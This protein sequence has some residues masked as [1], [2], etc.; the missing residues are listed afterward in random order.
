[1]A[2]RKGKRHIPN[3]I[4]WHML[5]IGFSGF[6]LLLFVFYVYLPYLTN[7]QQSITVPDIRGM[8][9]MDA[10]QFLRERR[11]DFAVSVDSDFS[12]AAKPLSVLKQ[13]PV[14]HAKVKEE[15]K[16]ILTLNATHP[17]MVKMP[18]LVDGSLKNAQIILH[19]LKLRIGKVRFKA[20]LAGNAVLEQHYQNTP[21]TPDTRIPQGAY[22]DLVVGDGLGNQ[23]LLAPNLIGLSEEEA[24]TVIIGSGLHIGKKYRL[25]S[26]PQT[27]PLPQGWVVKQTPQPFQNIFIGDTLHF[28]VGDTLR[29]WN[30]SPP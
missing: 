15:R 6:A 2:Q 9:V 29:F 13:F 16:I 22:I 1:M 4:L 20:D 18:Q 12:I 25:S 19:S 8:H 17:P 3:R 30:S 21:I 5:G 14:P 10:T 23:E 11:L 7:H 28:W 27:N 26:S 24:H